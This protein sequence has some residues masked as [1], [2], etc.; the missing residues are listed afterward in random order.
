MSCAPGYPGSAA[1][2]YFGHGYGTPSRSVKNAR[3][4]GV[5]PKVW[6]TKRSLAFGTTYD[7]GTPRAVSVVTLNRPLATGL[8]ASIA[9]VERPSAA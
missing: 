7:S 3:M 4:A 1:Y 8:G 2:E 6:S 9:D 5:S